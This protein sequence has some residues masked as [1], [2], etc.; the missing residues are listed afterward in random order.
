MKSAA[1]LAIDLVES[2]Y[3]LEPDAGAWFT[4]VLERAMPTLDRGL[5]VCGFSYSIRGSSVGFEHTTY[6]GPP[7][8]P[9]FRGIPPEITA[10]M[11][12]RMGDFASISSFLR[13]V[14][15]AARRAVTEHMRAL[16][17][18]DGL[19]AAFPDG[20]GGAIQF[21]SLS[22]A[23]LETPRGD[24]LAWRRIGAHLAAGWRLRRRLGAGRAISEAVMTESGAVLS[25]TEPASSR[26]AQRC[27]SQ[28]GAAMTLARGE[29]R[30]EAPIRA[31]ELWR[32]LIA[33]RWSLVE[34][35]EESGAT[36]L[37][38]YRNEPSLGRDPR[39]LTER[40]TAIVELVRTGA[41]NKQ[42]AYTVG[43]APGTVATHLRAALRKLGLSSRVEL[44][45]LQRLEARD[46]DRLALA[47]GQLGVLALPPVAP[48]REAA[49]GRL[50]TAEREVAVEAA[51]GLS[52]SEIAE[53]RGR[54]VRTVVNQLASVFA[55]LGLG[56]RAEL[57]ARL[58]S[59]LPDGS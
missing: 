23:P 2:A 55:K 37:V 52:N 45:R 56:S 35:R 43:L 44:A 28:H 13:D 3:R 14:P 16:G 5:G 47:D 59:E 4:G 12:R 1:A 39:G 6:L 50:T 26:R 46:A 19:V 49:L 8:L 53:A 11:A 31:L 34:R 48:R 38:A 32:G 24:R 21:C 30:R 27:L 22:E 57:A 29:L 18:A 36:V 51:R 10:Q 20:E 58:A 17:V 41:S 9:E 33:G 7:E 54:S 25:T 42:V 40:E 15:P